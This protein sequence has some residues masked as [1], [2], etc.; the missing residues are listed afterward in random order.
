MEEKGQGCEPKIYWE[1][2]SK[3]IRLFVTEKVE[4]PA[5][6]LGDEVTKVIKRNDKQ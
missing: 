1:L 4:V 3:V 5:K 6:Y 2:G